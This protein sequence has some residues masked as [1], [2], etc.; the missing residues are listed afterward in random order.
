MHG[1]GQR[2][3]TAVPSLSRSS[4]NILLEGDSTLT[5]EETR[6]SVFYSASTPA[7]NHLLR[8]EISF[9]L[10]LSKD[11][12]CQFTHMWHTCACTRAHPHAHTLHKMLRSK[13]RNP[14]RT[15]TW[16]V[17]ETLPH[18]FGAWWSF[19]AR[20]GCGKSISSVSR[21]NTSASLPFPDP[22]DKLFLTRKHL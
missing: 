19:W 22:P 16:K 12:T 20:V 9:S 3:S 2:T 18:S 21:M 8:Q 7:T 11:L 15:V 6:P 4:P 1:G 13:Q 5:E 10:D 17:C 14:F